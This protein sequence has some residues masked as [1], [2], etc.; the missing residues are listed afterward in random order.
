MQPENEIKDET[1]D[2]LNRNTFARILADSIKKY[3]YDESLTIGIM[4]SWG[5]GKSS[6]INLTTNILKKENFIIIHFNPWFFSNQENLYSQFFK[7]LLNELKKIEMN[8]N[9]LFERKIKPKHLM[10]RKIDNSINDYF[11]YLK[12]S[13]IEINFDNLYYSSESTSLESYDS[14]NFHKNQCEEYFSKIK[15]KIIVVIDDIDRLSDEEIAQVFTLVKSIADFKKFIYILSFDRLIISKALKKINSYESDK[16]VDKIIQ[17]PIYVPKI[18]ENKMDELILKQIGDIY[19]KQKNEHVDIYYT[20]FRDIF[21]Y[22][23]LFIKD[24]RDLKRYKNILNFYSN[25]FLEGLN[26]NDFFLLLAIHLFEHEL[27]LKIKNNKE[28]L[29]IKKDEFDE[30]FKPTMPRNNL[31]IF[32]EIIN[33]TKWHYLK[34][35]LVFL[36]PTLNTKSTE[37]T[38]ELYKEW[39]NE[40]RIC[41]EKYFENYFTLSLEKNEVNMTSLSQLIQSNEVN[42]IF[43]FF[44]QSTDLDFNHSLLRKFSKLIPE[45]PKENIEYFIKALMKS[46]DVMNV[47]HASRRYF[48]WIFDDLFKII[49]SSDKC[50]EI[51]EQC[52]K[53]YDNNVLTTT[54][55]IYSLAFDYGLAGINKNIKSENEMFIKEDHVKELIALTVQNIKKNS[56]NKDFLNQRFLQDMLSYWELLDN[57]KD[58]KEYILNNVKTDKEILSFLSKFQTIQQTKHTFEGKFRKIRFDFK[59]LDSYHGLDFYEKTINRILLDDNISHDIEEFCTNFINQ[60]DEYKAILYINR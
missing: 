8:N 28:K 36:F 22:L 16:F 20:E 24:I 46:G 41:S 42:E 1:D 45:I 52:I 57:K 12:D 50:Y 44:T 6:L 31:E 47:Y 2:E 34:E 58:V 27:F 26:I 33:E 30:N 39:Q 49:N 7:L 25:N 4:G 21:D 15:Q 14:L 17:I 19:D 35:L 37:L 23:K 11:N 40:H 56:E 60:L 18:N 9:K 32:E 29:I 54:E 43:E 38:C 59:K 3:E 55:Y 5:S 13:S 51:L 48:E 10:F 53:F